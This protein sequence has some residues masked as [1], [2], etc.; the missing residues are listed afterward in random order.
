LASGSMAI[1]ITL[2]GRDAECA[3][4]AG[5]LEAVRKTG[6]L[7]D[8][9]A[10]RLRDSRCMTHAVPPLPPVTHEIDVTVVSQEEASLGVAEF[11]LAAS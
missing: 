10:P 7:A 5:L 9:R 2:R 6:Q 3:A 1:Q 8:A 11:G 4:L